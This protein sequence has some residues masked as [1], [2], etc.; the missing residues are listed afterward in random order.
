[1]PQNTSNS[2]ESL[3]QQFSTGNPGG[4]RAANQFIG[5]IAGERSAT[6]LPGFSDIFENFRGN[7]LREANRASAGLSEAFG[8]QGA[9]FGSDLLRSQGALRTEVAERLI[10]GAGALRQQQA[11]E[12]QA[13]VGTL[14]APA[15]L[16][17]RIRESA[18]QRLMA[19]FFRRTAP[20]PLLQALSNFSTA[21]SS[22]GQPSTLVF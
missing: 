16:E 15:E 7:I 22:A 1:M 9:R 4:L 13:T 20:P 18:F 10:G 3:L 8:S 11:A 2:L 6:G 19:E 21:T 12:R 5:R 17:T 14:L